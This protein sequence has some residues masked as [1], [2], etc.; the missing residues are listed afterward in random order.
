MGFFRICLVSI[1]LFGVGIIPATV[2]AQGVTA[3]EQAEIAGPWHGR[4]TAPDGW[5]YEAVISLRVS[6][7]GATSGEINWTLRKSPRPAEQGK[8]GMTGVESVRGNYYADTGTLILEGYEKNDP[9]G[10]LGL[11][12][13]RLVVLD[14][15]RTMGGITRHHN[16]WNSQF[17]LSK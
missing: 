11:D 15:H 8:V 9:N 17:F 5:I 4:W 12:K 16:A 6:G 14:N 3:T 7:S 13:Y 10:I 2:A 1:F